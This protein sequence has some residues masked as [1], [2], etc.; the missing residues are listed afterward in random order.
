M[1]KYVRSVQEMTN[2]NNN[3]HDYNN[4]SHESS[5]EV[6]LK[7]TSYHTEAEKRKFI[8]SINMNWLTPIIPS[9]ICFYQ[10]SGQEVQRHDTK[11]S[12]GVRSPSAVAAI[13]QK[14]DL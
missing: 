12:S 11:L 9:Y 7:K 10:K 14:S 8:F 5:S 1:L 4:S 3:D 13:V 2:Y 6:L